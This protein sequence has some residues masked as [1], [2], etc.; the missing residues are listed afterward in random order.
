VHQ[1]TQA[2]QP[3]PVQPLAGYGSSRS[4]QGLDGLAI[5][6]YACAVLLPLAG[7]VIG[8]IKANRYDGGTNHGAWIVGVSV[9]AFVF[10]VAVLST[11]GN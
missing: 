7:L 8:L 5:V 11:G 2:T 3:A 1:A 10:W 6:G 4:S 9:L